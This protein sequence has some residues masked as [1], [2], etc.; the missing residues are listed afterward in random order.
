[1]DFPYQQLMSPF[2]LPTLRVIGEPLEF[3]VAD[4]EYVASWSEAEGQLS[5]SP[6]RKEEIRVAE[7]S[8]TNSCTVVVP[9]Q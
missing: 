7:K 6:R 3:L 5:S 9:W 2:L 4:I 1:M 8:S